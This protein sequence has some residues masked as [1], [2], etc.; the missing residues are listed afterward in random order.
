MSETSLIFF[1][2]QSFTQL[3]FLS[4][5]TWLKLVKR[6]VSTMWVTYKWLGSD[7]AELE[8]SLSSCFSTSVATDCVWLFLKHGFWRCMVYTRSICTVVTL[9]QNSLRSF[10]KD[11]NSH[12]RL[13]LRVIVLYF[14][15]Y[16]YIWIVFLHFH[17]VMKCEWKPYLG[18]TFISPWHFTIN[19]TLTYTHKIGNHYWPLQQQRYNGSFL[20]S[21]ILSKGDLITTHTFTLLPNN[22]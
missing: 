16:F 14:E 4:E 11:S 10:A 20:F 9:V 21:T 17:T 1:I 15:L 6:H 19:R 5:P 8:A 13:E 18:I 7:W 12:V 22:I 2:R 3:Q